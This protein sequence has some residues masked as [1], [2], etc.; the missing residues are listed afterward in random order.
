MN[1]PEKGILK[2]AASPRKAKGVSAPA[3]EIE[4]VDVDEHCTGSRWL[5]ADPDRLAHIIAI[6]AMGQAAHA[7]RIISE[8][9]PSEP[10]IDHEALRIDAKRR[11]SIRGKAA[12]ERD[13]SR[14]QRDGLIFEAISWVAAHEATCGKALLK[15]PHLSSTT[16]GL[17]GLMIELDDSGSAV[18]RATIFEDKCSDNPRTMFRDGIIPAFKEHHENKRASDLVATAAALIEKSGLDGTKATVAAARVLDK[19]FR[20]YRGGLAVTPSDDSLAR[21]KSLFKGYDELEG[22]EADQ[23]IGAT[24]ITS[25]DL[26]EWFA[27][28]AMS[29]I[30]YIDN[31]EAG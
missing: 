29:A 23:R 27:D 5:A 15:D 9:L 25:D 3:L 28:L 24:L 30:A 31:L 11:L 13:A 20:A 17:D 10:A 22:I 12:S 7:A 21:R 14:W 8:L 16:Q 6:I 4:A 1:V 2:P 18:L 19:Q 26:R